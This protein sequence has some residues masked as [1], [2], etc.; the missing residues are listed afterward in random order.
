MAELALCFREGKESGPLTK[1]EIND[2]TI[3]A[4]GAKAIIHVMVEYASNNPHGEE[5]DTMGIFGS[6]FNVL[7]WLIEPITDYLFGYGGQLAASEKEEGTA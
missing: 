7:E 5:D 2:I 6:V 4:Q 1:S 3:A